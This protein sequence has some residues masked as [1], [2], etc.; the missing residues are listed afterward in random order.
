MNDRS[1]PLK[2]FFS[3]VPKSE[4][5]ADEMEILSIWGEGKRTGWPEL[6]G[7]Y[8]CVILAEAGAGKSFEMEARAKCAEDEG[9]AAFFIRIED[10]EDGFENSFDVGSLESFEH[11]LSSQDEAWFF[12]DSIDEARLENPRA[13]EKAIKCFATRINFAKRRAHIFIS[14]RPY[15]WRARSDRDMLERYLPYLRPKVEEVSNAGE[16]DREK[17]DEPESALKVYLLNALD[18]KDIRFFANARGVQ[19]VDKL[20]TDLHRANLMQMA[21]R[22]FDLEGILAKWQA[23]Q[24]LNGRLE[25]LQHNIDLRLKEIDPN[26]AQRQPL[27][28]QKARHGARLLAAAVILTG[29]AGICVPD[30]IYSNKGI[31]AERVLGDWE[32]AD[33][34]A[35]LERGIFNDVLYGMVRFRH[36]DV[37]ELLA[38]EWFAEQLKNGYARHAIE[39]LFIREQY[40][41]SIVTPRLRPVLSWL[42]LFDDGLRHKALKIAPEIAVEGGDAAHLPFAERQALLHDIVSRIVADED[43]RS[44]RDNSAIA[45]IAQPDLSGDALRII[46]E[47]RS[48]VGAIFF[49]GRLVWQGNMHDCLPPLFEIAIDTERGAFARIAATRAVMTCGT[50]EQQSSLWAQLNVL[51]QPLP[52][53][54]LTEI[55]EEVEPDI[56]SVNSLL[57]SINKLEAYDR[58]QATGLGQA[59]HEFIDRLPNPGS[60]DAI[61]PLIAMVLGLNDFLDREPYIQQRECHVSQQFLWLLG[62]ATH[63]V[64]RLVSARSE[65]AMLLEGFTILLKGPT[66]QYWHGEGFDDYKS[67]LYQLVPAWKELND[68]L[69][70]HCIEDARHRRWIKKSERLIDDWPVQWLQHYWKFEAERFH[71]VLGFIATREFLD[72]KLVALSLAHRLFTQA[73]RPEGWLELLKCA[74]EGNS[75]LALQHSTFLNPTKSQSLIELEEKSAQQ[76]AKWKQKQEERKLNRTKWIERLKANPDVVCHPPGL[77]QGRVSDDQLWLLGEIEGSGFRTSRSDGADW[78]ALIPEFGEDVA[79]AYREAAISYWRNYTPGL[80]SEGGNTNSIPYSLV[81]AMAGLEI[82]AS[83]NIDFPENLTEAEVRHALRYIVW[84]LNGFPSWF[85]RMYVAYPQLVLEAVL[86]ELHWELANTEATKPTHYILSDLVYHAPWMHSQLVPSILSWLRQ[87]EILSSE[88]LG[89]GINILLNGNA[90]TEPVLKL[91]GS[92][93]ARNAMCGQ[94]AVWFALWAD[95]DAEEGIS[96]FEKWLSS[97]PPKEASHEAQRFI[98]ELMGTRRS[99]R[100]G[101]SRGSFRDIRHLKRLYILMHRYIRARDDI[102]RAG[103]GVY[104]PGLRDDAQDG[105]NALFNLLSEIPGKET[106]IALTELAK[107]HPD[108]TYR[109]WM[110]KRAYQRAEQDADLEF[111]TE[112]QVRDYDQYQESKPTTNRQLFELTVDRLLDLKAWVERGNDSPYKTWQKADGETELRNLIV[113]WLNLKSS[114]RYSCAQENELPNKQRPDIWTQSSQIASPVPIELKLLDKGWSGSELCERLRNQLA[115]DYLR[116]ETAGCGVFLLVWQGKSH[117]QHWQIENQPVPLSGLETA[118][119]SYWNTISNSF[120]CVAAIEVMLIDLTIREIKSQD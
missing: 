50:Q 107:E 43:N 70:W 80:R 84:E 101:Y 37:R 21:G 110:Q 87:H 89:Y 9:R 27:N 90:D 59:I 62:P 58:Y 113:G 11:W 118:L 31:D 36:R 94:S 8:R 2:R 112:Q 78:Q 91:V 42:I 64:E 81:F 92:K 83:E 73:D 114:G 19:Q 10:I 76:E 5:D 32:P 47:H 49:L 3:K 119:K 30:S 53:R 48:N 14:S 115:G 16:I 100:I 79:R 104:S 63:A 85:E 6:E 45:K 33:V 15:A 68:A 88:A 51:P 52:R 111:W 97:L 74:V 66:V 7:E 26:R 12:L 77:A 93:V 44:A 120:P 106:Y 109:P 23:D 95:F 105:R 96:V 35:L 56:A 20:I 86:T 54:L 40:G 71:D 38:A 22:P 60:L 24:T 69:F 61:E 29:E 117:Q 99:S 1:V 103:K 13:F 55:L 98:S 67:S 18:E 82:E 116:E 17:Q 72:D 46:T 4:A 108:E 28:R 25:L 41:H 39:S 75:E 57:V 102:E 65:A 34:Q